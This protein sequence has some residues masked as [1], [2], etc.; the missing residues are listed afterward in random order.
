VTD[1]PEDL[2]DAIRQLTERLTTTVVTDD[3][4]ADALQSVRAATERLGGAGRPRVLSFRIGQ[5]EDDDT[6]TRPLPPPPPPRASE[7]DLANYRLYNPVSGALN[8]LAA[9]LRFEQVG[10]GT[11]EAAVTFGVAYQGPPGYVHGAF[12]AGVFDDILGAA[13]VAGGNPGMTVKLEV[14]FLRPTPLRTPLRVVARHSGRQGRRIFAT[15][16]MLAGEE[17]TAEADGVFAEITPSR[18]RRLFSAFV[19]DEGKEEGEEEAHDAAL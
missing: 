5:Y 7:S 18:A 8:P 13:N 1:R 10:D 6:P 4:M 11:I 15:G 16:T 3:A 12:I 2:A 9:P 19:Q 14:R 17:V